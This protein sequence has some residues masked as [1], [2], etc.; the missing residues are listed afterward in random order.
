MEGHQSGA[1]VGGTD[2]ARSAVNSF[3]LVVPLNFFVSKS[4]VSRFGER[5]RDG[6]YSLV[7][8]LFAVAVP[9]AQPFLKVGARAPSAP[10]SR[11][12]C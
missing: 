7:N 2:P 9:R 3:F 6:Q 1:K 12:H 10:W 8:F 5:F 11:R 4:T